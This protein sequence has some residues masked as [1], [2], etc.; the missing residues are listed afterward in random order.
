MLEVRQA[1]RTFNNGLAGFKNI[2]FSI[3]EGET[4]GI[5]GTS[6]CGKSTFL[7]VLSGL[8]KEFDGEIKIAEVGRHTDWHDISRTPAHALAHSQRKHFIWK[9]RRK[10]S[11]STRIIWI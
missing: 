6:G 9:Q 7:R 4:V 3:Q 8:D 5:L 2:S 11:R 10:K 1:S